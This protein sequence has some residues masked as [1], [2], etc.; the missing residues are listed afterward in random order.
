MMLREIY[1]LQQQIAKK[2]FVIKGEIDGP[3]SIFVKQATTTV[4]KVLQCVRVWTEGENWAAFA[5]A[6]I[7]FT[8]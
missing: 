1:R 2:Y 7:L 5:V 4:Q 8:N 6:Y 3:K